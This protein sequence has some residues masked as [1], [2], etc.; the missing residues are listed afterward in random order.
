M[1]EDDRSFNTYLVAVFV[2]TV[3]V[4]LSVFM[5]QSAAG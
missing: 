3:I 4:L 1:T 2:I 5:A